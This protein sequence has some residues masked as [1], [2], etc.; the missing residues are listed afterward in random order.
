MQGNESG[1]PLIGTGQ[2]A[3]HDTPPVRFRLESSQAR[4]GTDRS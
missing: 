3:V 2:L 4:R 1:T